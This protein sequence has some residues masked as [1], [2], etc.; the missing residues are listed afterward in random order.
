MDALKTFHADTLLIID[1]MDIMGASLTK[2]DQS[3]LEELAS[4]EM[5][6]L[7]TSRNTALYKEMYMIPIKP[8][9]E[10]EQLELFRLNYSPRKEKPIELP[11]KI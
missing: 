7:I 8:L 5:H 4:M 10:E 6:V 3:V 9:T 11:T 1:N 2:E